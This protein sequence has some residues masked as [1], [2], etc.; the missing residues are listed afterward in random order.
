MKRKAELKF[1]AYRYDTNLKKLV[2]INVLNE[3]ITDYIMKGIKGGKIY[4][5]AML[6]DALDNEFKYYYM[7]KREHELSVGDLYE[8]DLNKYEKVSVYDQ[9]KDN[10]EVITDYVIQALDWY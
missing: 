2:R 1:Y 5:R 7:S 9:I 4:D 10:L 6:K 3:R 8:T